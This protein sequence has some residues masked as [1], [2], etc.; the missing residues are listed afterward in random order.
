VDKTLTALAHQHRARW[1]TSMRFSGKVCLVTGAGSGIGKA[2]AKRFASEGGK[3][4]VI[5]LNDQHGN[6][7]VQEITSAKGEAFFSKC[8]VG[9]PAEI[10]ASIKAAV[11]KWQR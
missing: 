7:T 9:D 3:V 10:K 8:N 2:T 1:G 6:Q 5:D 4:A 11:D